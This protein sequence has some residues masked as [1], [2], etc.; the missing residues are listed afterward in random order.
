MTRLACYAAA[1][2][3][4]RQAIRFCPAGNLHLLYTA[5]GQVFRG[6]GDDSQAEAW[7]RRA[8]DAAPDDAQ[9][10]IY[11]GGLLASRGRL[12]EAEEVHRRG[13]GC[14]KGCVDE[15]FLNLG[16]VLRAQGR[17]GEAAECL[18][19][20]IRRD[21]EY[22]DAKIAMRDVRACQQEEEP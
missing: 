15:A 16:L 2:Q 5:L 14:S 17:L 1:E 8:I 21:P 3:A 4:L 20:A 7:F 22:R 6:S 10:Y 13:T 9:G 11:L 12:D 19:E 18:A